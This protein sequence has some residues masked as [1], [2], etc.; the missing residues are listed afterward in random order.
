MAT[1]QIIALI[2]VAVI[3]AIL[4]Y[5]WTRPDTFRVARST[6]IK[7][8]PEK[9]VPLIE[10]FRAWTQ[11]SPYENRD[12]NLK[13]TYGGAAK[14]RGA[15]Y[16]WEGNKN[17]GSGAM[18][19]LDSAPQKVRIKLD[20]FKPFEAHN[21]A[22]FTMVPAGDGTTVTWDMHGPNVFMGKLMGVFMNMDKMVGTDFERGL[23]SMKAAAEK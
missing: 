7:A 4:I 14:G 23:A 1:W 6:T 3:A 12:P 8:P 11:W 10:D 18:E 19:I 15:T 22:E 2:V 13:R 20:F 17:V 5:A 16:T 9:I 21:I